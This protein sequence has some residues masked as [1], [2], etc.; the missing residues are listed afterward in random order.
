M[1][2]MRVLAH[3]KAD[4]HATGHNGNALTELLLNQTDTRLWLECMGYLADLGLQLEERRL[5]FRTQNF[6]VRDRIQMVK[7][8]RKNPRRRYI[9]QESEI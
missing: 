9:A 4:V 3:H 6:N 5:S 7:Q 2:S 1:D 8:Y